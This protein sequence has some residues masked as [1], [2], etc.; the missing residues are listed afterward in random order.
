MEREDWQ[1]I[2]HGVAKSQA[3]GQVLLRGESLYFLPVFFYILLTYISVYFLCVF[4]HLG[5]LYMHN[6]FSCRKKTRYNHRK[7]G[8]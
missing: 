7:Q 1:A 3:Y 4:I 8:V 5:S 6:L 2:V